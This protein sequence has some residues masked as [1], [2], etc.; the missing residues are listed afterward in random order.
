MKVELGSVCHTAATLA[1]GVIPCIL[2]IFRARRCIGVHSIY[3]PIGVTSCASLSLVD[4][5][6]PQVLVMAYET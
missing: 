5:Y 1:P 6:M 4:F 3:I 2:Y